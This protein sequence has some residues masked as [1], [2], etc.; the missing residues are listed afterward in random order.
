MCMF[1]SCEQPVCESHG[2]KCRA[3]LHLLF[4][5]WVFSSVRGKRETSWE[6]S[7]R[8]IAQIALT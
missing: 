8:A 1:V 6:T 2:D 3:W 5:G 4:A 7:N